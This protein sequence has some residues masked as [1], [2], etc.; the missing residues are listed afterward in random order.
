MTTSIHPQ[1]AI[2]QHRKARIGL[3]GPSGSGKTLT[4]L[5]LARGLAGPEGKIVVL[6]T[7]HES[8][9]LY[10]DI[11]AFD[12]LPIDE[13]FDP[14]HFVEVVKVVEAHYDV[15]VLDSA[16]HE[17]AGPGGCLE[18]V[19]AAKGKVGDNS[20]AAW[21]HV[22][23]KHNKFVHALTHCQ[24]D[25]ICTIR[26]KMASELQKNPKTGKMEPVELGMAPIQRE[27]FPYELDIVGRMEAEAEGVRLTITST[28]MKA[29]YGKK[30]LNP[31]VELGQEIKAWLMQGQAPTP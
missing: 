26:A 9:A 4:A 10:A 22:T 11:E 23:P 18:L 29:L 30:A 3:Y 25:L 2:C 8:S 17:W 19:D 6:D 24:A 27:E 20:W 12:L 16:T 15:I 13:P 28:R 7:E 14:L 5:K 21:S 31:G 1:P